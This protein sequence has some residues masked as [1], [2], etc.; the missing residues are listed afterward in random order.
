M[1]TPF[2]EGLKKRRSIYSISSDV[3]VPESKIEEIVGDAVKY[4]PSA[5]NSQTSRVVVL[6]GEHHHK[7]WEI[8]TK[9]TLRKV[10][11]NDEA[12]KA[13]EEKITSFLSGYGTILFFED[14]DIVKQLQNQFALYKDNFPIWSD[15]TSGMLQL[16]IWTSLE[17]EGLGASLQH[18]NPLI[19]DQVHS[20]FDIPATW[21]LIAQMPFGKPTAEA[22]EKE[23][24]PIEERV[25][26]LH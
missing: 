15:Q 6:F 24:Q 1:S 12:F 10:V 13:T 7:L 18:Y 11:N 19:D 17:L 25:K 2:I 16:V 4:T 22:G 21:K 20:E 26:I 9:D 5:F 23:F 8:I 3:I 14:T